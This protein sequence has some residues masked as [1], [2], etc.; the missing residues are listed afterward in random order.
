MIAAISPADYNFDE[1]N[2]T[3]R[4]ASRAKNI[5]NKPRVNQDPKDALLK[6][7]EDEI[8]KLRQII[9]QSKQGQQISNVDLGQS[10]KMLSQD[11][12]AKTKGQAKE[13]SVEELLAKLAQKGKKVKLLDE[14]ASVKELPRQ[15]DADSD[16]DRNDGEEPEQASPTKKKMQKVKKNRHDDE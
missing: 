14:S 5:K 4:Y 12:S 13:D 8:N 9:E 7:Y 6:Q 3:L 11:K 16:L 15:E 10:I 1:T 2:T